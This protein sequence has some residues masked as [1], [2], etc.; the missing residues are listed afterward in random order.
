[1]TAVNPPALP[2]TLTFLLGTLGSIATARFTERIEAIGLKPKD[3]GLLSLLDTRGPASQ[4]E[5][6]RTMGVAPSLVVTVA[7]RLEALG[8]VQRVRD[9]GDRRR[10]NLL[11]TDHGLELL[12]RCAA[13]AAELEAELTASLDA[14][15]REQLRAILST[16]AQAE[17][18]H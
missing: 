17:G 11:P 6:S 14:E 9:P 8:A 12:E 16:L 1:M 15:V 18:L 10:Q 3:V 7:D 5:V 13:I 2:T 4:L